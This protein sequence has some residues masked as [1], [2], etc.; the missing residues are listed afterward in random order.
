MRQRG[1]VLLSLHFLAHVGGIVTDLKLY[2]V[3]KYES[4]GFITLLSEGDSI[5]CNRLI[6]FL[7]SF[8]ASSSETWLSK[9]NFPVPITHKLAWE[10]DSTFVEGRLCDVG[11]ECLSHGVAQLATLVDNHLHDET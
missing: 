6:V 2:G 9:K 3:Y 8:F 10:R 7:T 11:R 1:D 4:I 5:Y